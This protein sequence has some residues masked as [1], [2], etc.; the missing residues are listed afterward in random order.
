MHTSLALIAL[1]TFSDFVRTEENEP[2]GFQNIAVVNLPTSHAEISRSIDNKG[3]EIKFSKWNPVVAES[4]ET[5][6]SQS[7]L[8]YRMFPSR[9]SAMFVE[10]Y[11]ITSEVDYASRPQ[12]G[13]MQIIIGE[14]RNEVAGAELV[15]MKNSADPVPEVAALLRAGKYSAARHTLYERNQQEARAGETLLFKTRVALIDYIRRGRAAASCPKVS[16]VDFHKD[17]ETEALLLDAWCEAVRKNPLNALHYCSIL[18]SHRADGPYRRLAERLEKRVITGRILMADRMGNPINTAAFSISHLN[19]IQHLLPE[20]SFIETVAASLINVGLAEPIAK[21]IQE[22][23]ARDTSKRSVVL[24]PILVEAY[25]SQNS[26]VPALDSAG[27]FLT[28]RQP[29][30]NLARLK[31]GQGLA[32]LQT[33]DWEGAF[34]ALN[35]AKALGVS[36]G[37][38]EELSLLEARM[39]SGA[40]ARELKDLIDTFLYN[41]PKLDG[42]Q[43]KW[44]SR[45]S[46]E[47][48]LKSGEKPSKETLARLPSHTLYRQA[49]RYLSFGRTK[50]YS[51]IMEEL[52]HRKDGWQDTAETALDIE[53]LKGKLAEIKKIMEQI[54]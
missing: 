9:Q 38:D 39:R 52:S 26:T 21:M 7:P 27:Y 37:T 45:I 14:V 5:A 44:I 15:N 6:L 20:V 29:P 17:K 34:N 51:S 31:R 28:Q 2:W 8:S 42:F 25:L 49:E 11:S 23:M 10:I 22:I 1:L 46:M 13:G 12:K 16:S 35:A 40:P 24:E 53:S 3:V 50:E 43:K 47:V 32:L 30:W 18:K 33:G 4:I 41:K 54:Q 36:W 48:S 19:V